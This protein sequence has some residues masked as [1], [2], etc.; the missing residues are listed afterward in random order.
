MALALAGGQGLDLLEERRPE[1]GLPAPTPVRRASRSLLLQGAGWGGGVVLLALF[2]LGAMAWWEGQQAQQLEALLPV[3]QQVRATEAK[4]RRLKSR[5]ATLAKDNKQIAKQ[6]VAVRSGSALLE[7]L[8]R[9]TPQG[10]QLKDL[11]VNDNAIKLSGAVQGGGRPGPLERINALVLALGELPQT[12][13]D[14]VKVVKATRADKGDA[15]T[16]NFS[17]TWALDPAVKPSLQRLQDL[18]AEGMAERLHGCW[19]ARE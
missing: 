9:I 8:R 1:L 18:G 5:T 16:V 12:L 17:L 4:L 6:L 11:S 15:A 19:S 14:G 3:E 13:A 2:G 10:I 7:Q